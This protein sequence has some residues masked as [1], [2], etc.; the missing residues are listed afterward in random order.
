MQD[1]AQV[2]GGRNYQIE[3]IMDLEK[4]FGL[5]ADEL[6]QQY[7]LGYYPKQLEAGQ[8]NQVRQIKVKV[9][10]PNLAVRARS[11]YTVNKK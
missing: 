6:R 1:L 3:N 8:K 11:S 4:T 2:T 10:Q 9:R 7:R 5:I